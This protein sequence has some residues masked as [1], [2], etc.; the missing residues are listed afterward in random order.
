MKRARYIFAAS[1]LTLSLFFLFEKS[2]VRAV[3]SRSTSPPKNID[4]L[5]V[6]IRLIRN[7]YIEDKDPVPTMNGS[8]QGLVNALD[9]TSSYLDKES[10]AR[11]LD[12]KEAQIREPGIILYKGYGAFPQIIGIIENS[13][14]QKSGLQIGDYIAEINGTSTPTMS[15]TE[16]NLYVRDK[17][18]I[19]LDLKI[20]R[21]DKT[22]EIKVERALLF[23]EPTRYSDQEGT[24]G[25]LKIAQLT[26]PSVSEIKMKLLPILKKS[27]KPLIVDLRNCQEGTFEEAQ[28]F[29]NLFLKAENI[30]YF[31]KKSG[32]KE[33]LSAPQEPPLGHLPLVIWINQATLGPAEVVAAVLKES[34]RAKVVGLPTP[35]LAARHEFFLLEDGTSIL[36]TSGI[37]C[38]NSGDKLW[39]QGAEP[40]IKVELKEQSFDA[41]IKRT[42]SLLSAP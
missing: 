3:S 20:L 5:E 16:V 1:L 40:D 42:R 33:I 9:S 22:L 6:V 36:L 26:P 4:L 34:K 29:I 7:D 37:F 10:T 23:A 31:E 14:A 27:K 41:F 24:S 12:Q 13:P 28:Q 38:L 15:L 19:P 32:T 25:I 21:G 30:G 2:I 17:E 8:F 35:G 18:D 11:Y 39:G